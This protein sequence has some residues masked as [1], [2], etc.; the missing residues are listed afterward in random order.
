MR[1]NSNSNGIT[2]FTFDACVMRFAR[3]AL[4]PLL[5]LSL[6]EKRWPASEQEMAD[7]GYSVPASGAA[8]RPQLFLEDEDELTDLSSI[9]SN[10]ED[11]RS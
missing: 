10:I 9:H 6:S 11:L 5:L 1:S 4:L 2:R 3:Q 8:Q 7:R